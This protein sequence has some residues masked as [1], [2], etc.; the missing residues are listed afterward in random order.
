MG[1]S[2][3]LKICQNLRENS[4]KFGFFV[5]KHGKLRENVKDLAH[6]RIKKYLNQFFFLPLLREKFENALENSGNLVSRKCGHPVKSLEDA[7]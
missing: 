7:F 4:E 3:N 2:G 1:N 6:L 5:G